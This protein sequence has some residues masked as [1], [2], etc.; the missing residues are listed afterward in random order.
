M[1]QEAPMSCPIRPTV[2][3]DQERQPAFKSPPQPK[4]KS[5]GVPK[6]IQKAPPPK[7]EDEEESG[8]LPPPPPPQV[9]HPSEIPKE[10]EVPQV[11]RLMTPER[12]TYTGNQRVERRSSREPARRSEPL[13][14]IPEQQEVIQPS[15]KKIATATRE[16]SAPPPPKRPPPVCPMSEEERTALVA[17]T[18]ERARRGA[19]QSSG[20]AAQSSGGAAQSSGED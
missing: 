12:K 6:A 17:E 3:S 18:L 16:D 1:H 4:T 2:K 15:P 8:L 13:Q 7:L 9:P 19:A 5:E 10:F 20:G 11:K 14:P